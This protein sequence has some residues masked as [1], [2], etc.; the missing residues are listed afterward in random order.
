[1]VAITVPEITQITRM[2]VDFLKNL[3][4]VTTH[5]VLKKR[6]VMQRYFKFWIT[7]HREQK[8]YKNSRFRSFVKIVLYFG[9]FIFGL[10]FTITLNFSLNRTCAIITCFWLKTA[11]GY[12][13]QNLYKSKKYI[14]CWDNFEDNFRDIF[15]FCW[16]IF[17]DNFGGQFRGQFRAGVQQGSKIRGGR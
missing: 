15:V 1:M 2:K 13:P 3:T 8:K 7:F 12:Y 17:G 11:L 14:K 9:G 5:M 16:D 6:S 4:N 10:L